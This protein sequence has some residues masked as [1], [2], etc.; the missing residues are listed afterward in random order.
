MAAVEQL[1]FLERL[2]H[3]LLD[4]SIRMSIDTPVFD[5]VQ[6]E[7]AVVTSLLRSETSATEGNMHSVVPYTSQPNTVGRPKFDISMEQLQY[8]VNWDLSSRDIANA[9]GVS[10]STIKRRLREYGIS[11]RGQTSEITDAN[12]D[13]AAREIQSQFPN[14]GYRRVHS[15]LLVQGIRISQ[16]RLRESLERTDP[17]GIAMRWLKQVIV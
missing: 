15:Q 3:V 1:Q 9:L 6:R 12:V 14:A 17:D 16:L 11:V 7:L 13:A 8:L 10:Q 4:L 2:R 5:E